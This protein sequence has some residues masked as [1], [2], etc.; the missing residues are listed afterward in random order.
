MS[1]AL[2]S[3]LT[4]QAAMEVVAN[5]IANSNTTGYCREEAVLEETSPIQEGNVQLG[6]GVTMA[7]VQSVRDKILN[8][9]IQQETS[10]D[11]NLTSY[12]N[13]MDQVQSLFNE[14]SS[15][16]LQTAL[17]NFFNS[18]SSLSADPTSSTLREAVISAGQNLAQA[19]NQSS[20]SLT[21]IRS[22]LDQS[23]EQDVDQINQLADQIANLNQQIQAASVSGE[24]A[25]TL[26]DQR[27]QALL[28][29]SKLVDTSVITNEDGSVNVT[30]TSGALLVA[31]NTSQHLSTQLNTETGLHDVYS[32]G[33]DITSSITG[34]D[35]K[36]LLDARD[37]SIPSVQTQLD[38]LAAGLISAVNKQQEAG[39]DENGNK[40]TAFFTPFT[41]STSGC[42]CDERG[43]DGGFPG[44]RELG[45]H[46]RQR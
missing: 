23:V 37:E 33:T 46:Q 12:V 25:G 14:T 34:G 2:Q 1:I 3:L 28:S 44:C 29:L 27:D 22:G 36:G 26:E 7:S 21:T 19:F 31:G 15:T 6:T 40:G 24:S 38:D 18:F 43:A 17:S 42:R 16:G 41:S 8:L 32:N 11:E 39:Y 45:R 20:Q 13:A 35:L 10:Q 30:T 5:N 9:R 4:Q